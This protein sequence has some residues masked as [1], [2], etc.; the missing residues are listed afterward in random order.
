MKQTS[1]LNP[2]LAIVEHSI[3][4]PG[5]PLPHGDSQY[6]SWGL[7]GFQRAKSLASRL[8][9][10][11]GESYSLLSVTIAYCTSSAS[12][13]CG[14]VSKKKKQPISQHLKRIRNTY[15]VL[16]ESL[17]LHQTCR[18][19]H[20]WT[21]CRKTHHLQPQPF[22]FFFFF[23]QLLGIKP[24]LH[25]RNKNRDLP[26]IHLLLW[27]RRVHFERSSRW[28]QQYDAH[29]PWLSDTL[30][31]ESP[32]KQWQKHVN[33]LNNLT[34]VW[35]LKV[36]RILSLKPKWKNMSAMISKPLMTTYPSWIHPHTLK[37]W[38]MGKR[39]P[40]KQGEHPCFE[41]CK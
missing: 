25:T 1:C 24:L 10:L 2:N 40:V 19:D 37:I 39:S 15:Q 22:F 9:A 30:R 27:H 18:N 38:W 8:F 26:N 5:L 29:C 12:C 7:D 41:P 4:Q 28:T 6:G 34:S 31:E 13:Q 23:L 36:G 21:G 17:K 20:R 11:P 33:R 14:R 3:C 16:P 35:A 32:Q